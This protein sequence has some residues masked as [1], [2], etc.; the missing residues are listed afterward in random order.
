MAAGS[1]CGI[2]ITPLLIGLAADEETIPVTLLA[3]PA[4]AL[5][6]SVNDFNGSTLCTTAVVTT[7]RIT[8]PVT[9]ASIDELLNKV[10]D[11]CLFVNVS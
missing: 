2:I 10:A 5:N 9:T 3:T 6:C 11:S 8:T 7:T 1:L 4:A